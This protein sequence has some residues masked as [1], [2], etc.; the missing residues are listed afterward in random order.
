MDVR[1]SKAWDWDT[2]FQDAALD[3]RLSLAVLQELADATGSARAQLI[4][5]GSDLAAHFYW[6]TQ[7]EPGQ[8]DDFIRIEGYSPEINYRIAADGGSDELAVVHEAHYDEARRSLR[9]GGSDVDHCEQYRIPWRCRPGADARCEFA[10]RP[11]GAAIGDNDETNE[12]R[13]KKVFA[14][15]ARAGPPT[16]GQDAAGHRAEG[17]RSPL[18]IFLRP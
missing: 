10:R 18:R 11:F 3:P 2:R 5:L 7:V 14:E 4:G 15:A 1:T 17:P 12:T 9:R 16:R 6:P 8:L 13:R